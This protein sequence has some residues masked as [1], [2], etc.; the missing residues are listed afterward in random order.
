[1][2]KRKG[3]GI[4]WSV[5]K[6]FV[7]VVGLILILVGLIVSPSPVPFGFVPF[8]IG[9]LLLSAA[10]PDLIRWLRRRWRW[11]DRQLKRLEKQL[12][13]WIARH[14]RRSG[15]N[16]DDEEETDEDDDAAARRSAR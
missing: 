12:P 5:F 16:G 4:F 7:A 6:F 13:K 11:L 3:D 10:A 2:A 8:V 1:M 15:V 9:L 14:L